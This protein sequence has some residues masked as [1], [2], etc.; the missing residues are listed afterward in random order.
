MVTVRV[1]ITPPS[2]ETA[3]SPPRKDKGKP[4]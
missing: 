2:A 3:T 1:P 4:T